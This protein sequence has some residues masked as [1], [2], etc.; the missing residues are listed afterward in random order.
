MLD[1]SPAAGGIRTHNL[2]INRRV[3]LPLCYNLCWLGQVSAVLR[4]GP[5]KAFLLAKRP[6]RS[7]QK[8]PKPKPRQKAAEDF[9]AK[10]GTFSEDLFATRP[11]FFEPTSSSSFNAKSD[12]FFKSAKLIGVSAALINV[13][14]T[15]D[16][17]GFIN[18]PMPV[19]GFELPLLLFR[20]SF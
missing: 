3:A 5:R 18:R 2:W 6:N 14:L 16:S 12:I 17:G 1:K 19:A 11:K 10:I 7:E 8:Q 13:A 9:G 20:I 15:T 4:S